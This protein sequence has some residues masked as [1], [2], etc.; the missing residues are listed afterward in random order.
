MFEKLR[1]PQG[2]PLNECLQQG[3]KIPWPIARSLFHQLLKEEQIVGEDR[4]NQDQWSLSRIWIDEIGRIT[5][6]DAAIIEEKNEEPPSFQHLIAQVALVSLPQ[7]HRKRR[8]NSLVGNSRLQEIHS[9][10]DLAPYRGMKLLEKI[11]APPK[12]QRL[13]A[14]QFEKDLKQLDESPSVVNAPTRFTHAAIVLLL[15]FPFFVF[16]FAFL[17]IQQNKSN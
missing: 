10:S 5:F 1:P 2:I 4:I 12:G 16:G 3:K 15:L 17:A 8:A 6:S 13:D 7:S 9:V 14:T 11:L